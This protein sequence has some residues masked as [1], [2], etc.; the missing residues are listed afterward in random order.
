MALAD[1]DIGARRV[2]ASVRLTDQEGLLDTLNETLG[3]EWYAIT[4]DL[5]IIQA[6]D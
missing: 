4:D 3:L 2:L 5:I 6:A 1:P